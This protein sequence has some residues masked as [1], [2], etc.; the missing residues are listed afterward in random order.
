VYFAAELMSGHPNDPSRARLLRCAS[1]DMSHPQVGLPPG[2]PLDISSASLFSPSVGPN[3]RF[4][5]VPGGALPNNRQQQV[6][7]DQLQQQQQQRLLS[8]LLSSNIP[9]AAQTQVIQ[10]KL[11]LFLC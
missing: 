4:P 3:V 11:L 2:A 6:V 9:P 8:T 10:V 1:E 5:Q 7:V